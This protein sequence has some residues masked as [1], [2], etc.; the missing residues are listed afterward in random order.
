MDVARD[1]IHDMTA[2]LEL[3]MARARVREISDPTL[4]E[5]VE[6]ALQAAV[7]CDLLKLVEVLSDLRIPSLPAPDAPWMNVASELFGPVPAGGFTEE[8]TGLD[9]PREEELVEPEILEFP[10]EILTPI[11]VEPDEPQDLGLEIAVAFSEDD[12]GPTAA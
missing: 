1:H 2:R 10:E 12:S 5:T 9:L 3:E 6:R 4:R 11:E 7:E 8:E